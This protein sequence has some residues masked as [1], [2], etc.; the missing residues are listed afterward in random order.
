MKVKGSGTKPARGGMVVNGYSADWLRKGFP[1][2]YPNEVVSRGEGGGPTVIYS[3][4]GEVLGTGLP[5]HGFL[6]ARVFRHDGGAIDGE[7]LASA[8]DRAADLRDRVIGPETTAFRLVHGENDGL[9]GL[10]IDVWDHAAT[11]LLDTPALAPTLEATLGWL[12][13]RRAPRS[14]YLHY[15]PDPR[16]E[17]DL[18]QAS[19]RPGLIYGHRLAA[20]VR[21]VERGAAAL[22]RPWEGTDTGLYLDMRDVRAWMEPHW[23]G[24]RV[25]NLFAYTGMFSVVAARGGASEVVTVDLNEKV[26]ERAEANFRA[27]DLDPLPHTFAT[28]DSFK[29]LDRLRRQGERFDVVILD[30]PSFSHGPDGPWSAKRDYPRLV[31]AACRVLEP[32]GW[33]LA[34][35]NHGQ[36]SPRDFRGFVSDGARRADRLAQ[37]LTWLGQPADFPAGTWFPEARYLKVGVWRMLTG[38]GRSTARGPK[39]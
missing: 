2:V 3:Q 9:P 34:A 33:L 30:P 13:Q 6:A 14:V 35:T 5:D 31:A 10:R 15:R 19:P 22:V 16:D 20:D 29:A 27:N 23:G 37:E 18:S 17:R 25:L 1:W 12:V 24:R 21:V 8:L 7:F 39:S 38:P 28:E 11:V 32:D 36:T 26:L 4:E